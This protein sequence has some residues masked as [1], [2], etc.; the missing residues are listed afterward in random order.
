MAAAAVAVGV[1]HRSPALL[2]VGGLLTGALPYLSYGLL[3]LVAVL[4]VVGVV[5]LQSI[6]H[7]LARW[8]IGA[9]VAGLLLLPVLLTAGG[10]WWLD[11]VVA[12][13]RAW[14]GGL[15]DD[16]PYLYSFLA[17]FA[18]LGVLVGPATAVAAVLRPP[19]LPVLPAG[20]ALVGVLALALSGVTRLAVERIWLPFAPWTVTL[21]AGL[22]SWRQRRWLALN[23]STALVF[24]ALV[25]DAW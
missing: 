23:A 5:A 4:L 19:R 12:T 14:A 20:A 11:G 22:P 16:R 6:R 25:L 10:F 15:G 13:H 2:A 8:H 17:H 24:Q 21:C 3:P 9:F 18:L 1:Q 7:G